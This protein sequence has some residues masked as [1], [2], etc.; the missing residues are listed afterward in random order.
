[1]DEDLI[2]VSEGA[3][4]G[5]RGSADLGITGRE[6]RRR[7]VSCTANGQCERHSWWE[8]TRY[9]NSVRGIDAGGVEVWRRRKGR[10]RSRK[11]YSNLKVDETKVASASRP[12]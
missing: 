7:G 4:E 8:R 9:V 10:R 3:R 1:M 5:G 12:P 2:E 6:D 11:K